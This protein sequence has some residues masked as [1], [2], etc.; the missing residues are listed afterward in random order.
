MSK[1]WVFIAATPW[2]VHSKNISHNENTSANIFRLLNAEVY[3]IS[4]IKNLNAKYYYINAFDIKETHLLL[5]VMDKIKDNG[6]KSIVHFS[7]DGR[8]IMGHCLYD[9]STNT[10]YGDV[11]DKAN[12]IISEVSPDWKCY[13]KNQHK[14]IPLS[15]N[16]EHINYNI[17]LSEKNI[18]IFSTGPGGQENL[19]LVIETLRYLKEKNPHFK[20]VCATASDFVAK[21]NDKYPEIEFVFSSPHHNFLETLKQSKVYLNLEPRPRGGRAVEWSYY[22]KTPAVAYKYVYYSQLYP[23]L[24]YDKLDM[25]LICNL[26]ETAHKNTWQHYESKA[27]EFA[28]KNMFESWYKTIMSRLVE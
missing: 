13:G 2:Q 28:E 6:G 3:H 19:P 15:H 25:D 23:E 20:I 10:G 9:M 12:F 4:D 14:V 17:D 18:D 11:C 27:N 5:P 1:D 7:S 21:L 24:C 16:M 8:F 26:L 22:C